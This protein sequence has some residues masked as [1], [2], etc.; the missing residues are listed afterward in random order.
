MKI[1]KQSLPKNTPPTNIGNNVTVVFRKTSFKYCKFK[2][3]IARSQHQNVA[4]NIFVSN[5]TLAV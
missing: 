1:K 4:T 3:I 5:L 2:Q